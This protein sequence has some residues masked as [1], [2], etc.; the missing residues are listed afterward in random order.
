[1]KLIY[2]ILHLFTGC[3]DEDLEYKFK[4]KQAICKKCGR[5]HFIF[6]KF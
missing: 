1:M 2:Y 4:G 3:P 6:N 5:V